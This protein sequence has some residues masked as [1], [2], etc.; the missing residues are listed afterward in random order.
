MKI[1][2]FIFVAFCIILV[3]A[4][5][6]DKNESTKT[7]VTKTID[8]ALKSQF[9]AWD[10]SHRKTVEY[11]K[12]RMHDPSSFKHV[13]TT[14]I[15]NLAEGHRFIFMTYRGKNAFNAVVTNSITAKVNLKG[16]VL[17]VTNLRR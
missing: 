11:V 2:M 13:R 5:M 1:A 12:A 8:P 4:V 17:N 9:S 3:I 10:G 6:E 14:Y 16:D 7:P 15:D